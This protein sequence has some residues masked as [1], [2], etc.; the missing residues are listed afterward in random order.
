[1]GSLAAG[2]PC[3]VS[4][5]PLFISSTELSHPTPSG[6]SLVPS[7]LSWSLS[8]GDSNLLLLL[9]LNSESK[10]DLTEL[11][12]P[13]GNC[14]QASLLSPDSTPSLSGLLNSKPQLPHV[15]LL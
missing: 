12:V 1:M 9:N 15:P 11:L 4:L 2:K 3:G 14:S 10:S 13:S 5:S 8:L 7:S 6:P